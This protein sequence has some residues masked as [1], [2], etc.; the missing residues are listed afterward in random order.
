[1]FDVSVVSALESILLLGGFTSLLFVFVV[2]ILI[3]IC[4]LLRRVWVMLGCLWCLSVIVFVF[5]CLLVCWW[6]CFDVCCVNSVVCFYSFYLWVGCSVVFAVMGYV[7]ACSG[8]CAVNV[9]DLCCLLLGYV[10]VLLVVVF[11]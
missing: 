6:C 11:C 8:L 2:L 9:L 10:W 5:V 7:F 3:V 1:M 4:D